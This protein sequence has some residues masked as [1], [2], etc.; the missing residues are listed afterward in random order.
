[1]FPNEMSVGITAIPR[2]AIRRNDL[3]PYAE[4][5]WKFPLWKF[6]YFLRFWFRPCINYAW[7]GRAVVSPSP[8][9]V[10]QSTNYTLKGGYRNFSFSFIGPVEHNVWWENSLPP[11]QRHDPAPSWGRGWSE[12]VT[13]WATGRKSR[14]RIYLSQRILAGSCPL[15][16]AGSCSCATVTAAT[17]SCL[18]AWSWWRGWSS[19][20]RSRRRR[21]RY[22]L[23]DG[24]ASL[25]WE[26]Q[27][28][29]L[30]HL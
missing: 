22:E 24:F 23:D 17:T 25:G 8:Q 19:C 6:A 9:L 16:A 20:C 10:R 2:V 5:W 13:K 14:R 30:L 12:E 28:A 4:K 3:K 29:I 15:V 27:V 18:I 21:L 11:P 1:M 26:N 7:K